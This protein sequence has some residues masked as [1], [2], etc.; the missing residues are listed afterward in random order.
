MSYTPQMISDA[1][2]N[3]SGAVAASSALCASTSGDSSEGV[4]SAIVISIQ[5]SDRGG[6]PDGA[7]RPTVAVWGGP[8]PAEKKARS[9][10]FARG[11]TAVWNG[12]DPWPGLLLVL[13]PAPSREP[14]RGHARRPAAVTGVEAADAFPGN[15]G[16]ASGT[17]SGTAFTDTPPA[18]EP[19]GTVLAAYGGVFVAGSIAWGMAADGY[20]P[21]RFD[22]IGALLCLAGMALIMYAPRG[23]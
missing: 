9:P 13:R 3:C 6:A 22:V 21:D 2:W 11:T 16:N 15:A 4:Y 19:Q 20:R 8:L 7:A 1:S 10:G 14:R 17:P 18:R 5:G 12:Y 23:S